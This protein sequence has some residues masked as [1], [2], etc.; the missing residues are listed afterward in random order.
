M[1]STRKRTP[2]AQ[3]AAPA[4]RPPRRLFFTP[5]NVGVFFAIVILVSVLVYVPMVHRAIATETTQIKQE[6]E[7]LKQQAEVFK[8]KSQML[9]IAREANQVMAA[10][11]NEEKKYFLKEQL[12]LMSFLEEWMVPLF[13]KWGWPEKITFDPKPVFSISW[14]MEPYE[15]IADPKLQR[16]MDLFEWKYIGEGTGSGEVSMLPANF[17]EPLTFKLEGIYLTYENLKKMIKEMQTDRTYLITVHAFKNSGEDDNI[18]L[19]RTLA[20][21]EILFS[22]YFMNPEGAV[23]GEKPPGMP[24]DKHL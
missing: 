3:R 7:R 20:K 8:K 5:L 16:L 14:M 17:L 24:D 19:L 6:T 12:E 21:Y 18:Y 11:L 22:V 10:K 1:S 2:A 4:E 23:S 15:T 9:P 13:E